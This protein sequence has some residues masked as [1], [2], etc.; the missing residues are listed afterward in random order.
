MKVNKKFIKHIAKLSRFDLTDEELEK[1]TSQMK[2]ILDSADVLQKVDVTKVSKEP[3]M[4]VDFE[5]LREDEVGESLSQEEA[6]K[7][8][9]FVDNGY[10]KAIG[11]TFEEKV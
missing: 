8:A 1:F 10:I 5:E 3:R 7:N 9:S 11:G 6:I 4:V 2:T